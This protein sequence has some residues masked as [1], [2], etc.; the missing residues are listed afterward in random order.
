MLALLLL[1]MDLAACYYRIHS[2]AR[3]LTPWCTISQAHKGDAEKLPY[4][5][6]EKMP[7][8]PK[9][10]GHLVKRA[11]I[12]GRNWKKRFFVLNGL[13]SKLAYWRRESEYRDR[14]EPQGRF[15]LASRVTCK[16]G[17]RR[18]AGVLASR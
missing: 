12:S 10:R 16:V 5:V 6:V 7:P 4:E 9:E 13:D 2:L 15:D 8:L 3:S 17:G 11:L 14:W 18:R 1:L